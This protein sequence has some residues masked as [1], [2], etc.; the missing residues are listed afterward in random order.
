[1]AVIT[2][3]ERESQYRL[4]HEISL[5]NILG[6]A[7]ASFLQAEYPTNNIE[8][9]KA[10]LRNCPDT[11]NQHHKNNKNKKRLTPGTYSM[12]MDKTLGSSSLP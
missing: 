7:G 5:A 4:I 12:K 9:L 2:E 10:W 6:I 8:A 1:M 11:E 3:R